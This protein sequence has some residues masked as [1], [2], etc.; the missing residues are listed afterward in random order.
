M[1]LCLRARA[2]L[3]VLAPEMRLVYRHNDMLCVYYIET[4]LYDYEWI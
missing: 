2:L 4:M 3:G 1:N